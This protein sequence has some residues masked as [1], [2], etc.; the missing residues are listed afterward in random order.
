MERD[1]TADIKER[2]K[3]EGQNQ[4]HHLFAFLGRRLYKIQKNWMNY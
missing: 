2:R 1:S 4:E 3:K